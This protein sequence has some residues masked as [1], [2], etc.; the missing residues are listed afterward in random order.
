MPARLT[1]TASSSSSTQAA[2]GRG[3]LPGR[4]PFL[5]LARPAP[6]EA[7]APT[8]VASPMAAPVPASFA[9]RP[10]TRRSSPCSRSAS[11]ARFDLDTMRAARGLE[12]LRPDMAAP[13]AASKW[14]RCLAEPARPARRLPSARAACVAFPGIPKHHCCRAT[15]HCPP[16]TYFKHVCWFACRVMRVSVDFRKNLG[17]S[18]CNATPRRTAHTLEWRRCPTRRGSARPCPGCRDHHFPRQSRRAQGA[19]CGA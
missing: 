7:P 14:S 16:P 18:R 8:A 9:A 11:S 3:R 12:P 4:L 6:A 1:A 2:L 13:A 19:P 15:E 5:L 10:K 17:F